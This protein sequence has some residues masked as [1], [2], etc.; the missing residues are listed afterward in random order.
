MAAIT[1]V[2]TL[3]LVA[4][5]VDEDLEWLSEIIGE[6][7]PED[8]YLWIYGPD[9]QQTQGLTPFGLENLADVIR[10]YKTNPRLLPRP[11]QRN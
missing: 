2:Y 3:P 9:D 10:E 4:Q 7:E 11:P 5:M 6:M 8:G 1:R